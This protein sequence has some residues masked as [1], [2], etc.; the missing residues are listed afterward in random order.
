MA[1]LSL[2]SSSAGK[3]EEQSSP[4]EEKATTKTRSV[5]VF[6]NLPDKKS[7]YWTTVEDPDV[8]PCTIAERIGCMYLEDLTEHCRYLIKPGD[9]LH[10]Q[11][12]VVF[13]D[14]EAAL[15]KFPSAFNSW[16]PHL[17]GRL[18]M[19]RINEEGEIINLKPEH[20]PAPLVA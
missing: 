11:S 14:E 9:K 15:K 18:V 5:L 8:H 16:E 4:S 2:S 19:C 17:R 12:L 7:Q 1:A 6:D 13:G 3:P 20:V 10:K